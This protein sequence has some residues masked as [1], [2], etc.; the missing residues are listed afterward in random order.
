MYQ[1]I[2]IS[3][4]KAECAIKCKD[5]LEALSFAVLIKLTF[6]SSVVQSA[7]IRRCKDI[8][9][10]GSS[11][12]SR[13]ISNSL[14][15]GYITKNNNE[16]VALP[17][18][19]ENSF[20]IKL[21]LLSKTYSKSSSRYTLNEIMDII[22]DSVLLNHIKKQ[23]DCEN[24][25][26]LTDNPKTSKGFKVAKKRI[27][28]MSHTNKAFIGLSM[29]KISKL[30]MVSRWKARRLLNEL[31]ALG[32]IEKNERY[33]QLPFNVSDLTNGLR[34]WFKETGCFGYLYR[35]NGRVCCRVSNSYKYKG[36][37]IQ[38]VGSF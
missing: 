23:N 6:V 24:T 2:N 19:E 34:E 9:G 30:L 36:N 20:N 15:Y 26:R 25:F 31:L 29:T 32:L 7:T 35:D 22:R 33:I 8:F 18:K 4:N 38:W 11:R 27:N 21:R 28:R 13:V 3:L 14:K 16:L 1:T 10:I 5:E 12:I 37:Q 17:V